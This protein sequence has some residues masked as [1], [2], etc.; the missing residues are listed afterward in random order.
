MHNE[1]ISFVC[2]SKLN[3]Y[4]DDSYRDLSWNHEQRQL[5]QHRTHILI[6]KNRLKQLT[7][8]Q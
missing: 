8:Y 5:K 6:N 3:K 1:E 4:G 2:E 7:T